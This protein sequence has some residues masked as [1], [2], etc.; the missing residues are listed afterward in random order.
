MN[1]LTHRDRS[2]WT[3]TVRMVVVIA[4]MMVVVTTTRAVGTR[5]RFKLRTLFHYRGA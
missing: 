2:Q 1:L 5:F 4:I 3:V